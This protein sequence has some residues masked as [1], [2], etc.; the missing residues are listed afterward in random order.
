[1]LDSGLP[2]LVFV[3][4]KFFL[5]TRPAALVALAAGVAVALLRLTRREPLQQVVSGLIGLAFA[6]VLA[7]KLNGGNGTGF[8]LPGVVI[9]V[10]YGVAFGV[11]V[12]L[13][14][15]LTG[16]LVAAVVG[17]GPGWRE[18]RALL[19][20]H[21]VTSLGWTLLYLSKAGVQ[22]YLLAAGYG[23]TELGI[24]RLAMGY[25]LFLGGLGLSALYLRRHGALAAREG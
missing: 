13:R 23:T 18:D 16:V 24:V 6:A 2:T 15:P 11:S 20:A 8:F 1:M 5:D 12:L 17:S 10:A 22:G 9:S 4:A 25:P 7:V 14:R 19:R 21:L 3:I